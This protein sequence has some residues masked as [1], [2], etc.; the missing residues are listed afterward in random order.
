MPSLWA[1]LGFGV[2]HR[3]TFPGK[4]ARGGVVAV[5]RVYLYVMSII[6][7]VA[8]ASGYAGGEAMRILLGH[9]DVEIGAVTAASSAGTK[10]SE[11]HAHLWPLA[12]RV[13]EPTDPEILARHDVV[14][15]GLPHGASGEVT[16]ALEALDFKG[17]ILDLG[18]DHRLTDPAAWE[19]YYGSDFA[20]AW[21]YGMPELLVADEDGTPEIVAKKQ[22]E[23]LR[24]ARSIA[25]PG[26]NVTA[27]TLALQPG[28]A[29]G[30]VDT[31][32]VVATLAVG[33]SGAGKSLKPHL[34][35]SEALGNLQPYAVGG[36]HRHIPEI[37]QNFKSA[38]ATEVGI[39]FTPVLVPTSRGIIATVSAPVSEKL[40]GLDLAEQRR[41]LREAWEE[42]YGPETLIRVLPE[43]IWPTGAMVSGAST[44]AVQVTV[45][46]TGGPIVDGKPVGRVVA[47]CVIDNVG[48]GTAAAAVQSMNIA[49]GMPE[50]RG[51]TTVAVAP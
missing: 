44:A 39:N 43:G 16:A 40:R 45:D 13:I 38:G 29:A 5:A 19:H 17:V 50:Y 22:R 24:G 26:C 48:K 12:D 10:I 34:L 1:L 37:V 33:Y 35:A 6:V 41:R 3:G 25:V 49:L 14:I 11:H 31:G 36:T 30:L 47:I 21:P 7:A 2:S 23:I 15:I 8:G 9:P 46:P 4:W 27:V 51:L 28:V 42:T 18:A 32:D 20:G